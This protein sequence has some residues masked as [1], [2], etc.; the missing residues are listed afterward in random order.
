MQNGLV[1]SSLVNFKRNSFFR[2]VLDDR[3]SEGSGEKGPALE[4]LVLAQLKKG[5]RWDGRKG[6]GQHCQAFWSII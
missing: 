2:Y 4:R 5:C 6:F 3:G 1:L